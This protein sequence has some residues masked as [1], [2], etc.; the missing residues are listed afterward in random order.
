[1]SEISHDEPAAAAPTRTPDLIDLRSLCAAAELGSLGRAAIR[2]HVSQPALSK[3]LHNLE[4]IVGV[5]LLERSPHGVKLTPAGRRLYEEARRLLEQADRVQEVIGGLKRAGGP[6]RLAASHSAV[7]SFV[8]E[9]LG[10]LSDRHENGKVEL[11][12][13]NSS[14]V[15]D[16][17]ADAR[18]DLGV[19]ASRPHR[20]PY[21]G[22]RETTVAA[23]EVVCA[24]PREH[25]W[26]TRE[27]ISLREFLRTPMVTRDMGSNSRWTIDAVLRERG[28]EMVA[29]LVEAPSP[30]A[31]RREA[32]SHRTPILVSRHVLVG[33]DFHELRVDGLQ[34]DREF[35]LV[36]PAYGEPAANVAHL[37]EQL[38]QVAG[39]WRGRRLT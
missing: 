19:A 17:V 28:L 8:G 16:L 32:R 7:E 12:T 2:L 22:V 30:Q 4:S 36:L 1:M 15:R 13:A 31:A 18:A 27:S 25:P 23:D 39:R 37:A 14:V 26:S 5:E 33:H 38:H 20:T 10:Q 9:L 3:R 11:I 6:V 21:P 34:F 24:V 29:P 35:V